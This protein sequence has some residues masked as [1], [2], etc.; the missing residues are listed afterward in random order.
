MADT[1]SRKV[2]S[3][4]MASIGSE[5]TGPE[6]LLRK[7]LRANG[8]IGWKFQG[9]GITGRPDFVFEAQK[10]AVFVDG[11]FWHGC[12]TCC[13][14]PK[15][16]RIYWSKKFKTNIL[17]DRN[18]NQ[19]L[20]ASGWKIVRFWEHEVLGAADKCAKRVAAVIKRQRG[21]QK[22]LGLSPSLGKKLY[23]RRG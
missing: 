22:V 6:L 13:R 7:A 3:R 23:A 19:E 10:V 18:T 17:R 11:C 12:I 20:I 1:V 21:S 14:P 8:L 9:Y 16:N 2:R 15:S 4:I 5:N